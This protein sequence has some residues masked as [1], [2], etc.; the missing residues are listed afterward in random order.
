MLCV[1][2]SIR[3]SELNGKFSGS[4]FFRKILQYEMSYMSVYQFTSCLKTLGR[5][6]DGAI[7][8]G[9]FSVPNAHKITLNLWVLLPES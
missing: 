3:F 5:Q 9:T 7:S 4:T 1:K 6:S 8:V 2:W